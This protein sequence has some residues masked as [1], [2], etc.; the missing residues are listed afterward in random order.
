MFNVSCKDILGDKEAAVHCLMDILKG[1]AERQLRNDESIVPSA[2]KIVKS[3]K[4]LR[5]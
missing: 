5:F 1:N 3:I 2:V 4:I